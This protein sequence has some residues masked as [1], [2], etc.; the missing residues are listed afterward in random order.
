MNYFYVLVSA[1]MRFESI[2]SVP[3][4]LSE[5]LDSVESTFITSPEK[6]SVVLCDLEPVC[7]SLFGGV[8]LSGHVFPD[9]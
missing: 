6:P 5:P 7:D 8:S 3:Y 9:A 4:I 2:P 1:L